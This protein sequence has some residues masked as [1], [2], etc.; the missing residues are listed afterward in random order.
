[1]KN[2]REVKLTVFWNVVQYI[3]VD[4]YQCFGGKSCLHVLG[5]SKTNMEIMV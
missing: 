2:K 4:I 5:R 1:M 3:L